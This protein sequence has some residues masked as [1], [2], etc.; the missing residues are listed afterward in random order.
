MQSEKLTFRNPD[1]QELA[2]ILDRPV[3]PDPAA[4]ALFAHCFTCSK[5][6]KAAH[7]VSRGLTDAGIAVLR[8]DF[9]GLGESEGEFANT[10]FS[11]NVADLVAAAEFLET[12]YRAPEIL[13]GHSL[14]GAA[15]LMAGEKIPSIRVVATIAAPADPAH[16]VKHLGNSREEIERKGEATV[17]LGGR[18]FQVRKQF[19][20]DLEGN[21]M[22]RSI[23]A[24]RR[25]AIL[26]FHSPL[27]SV[28]GI[29][30]AVKIYKAAIHPKSFVSLD[31]ADH[32]LSDPADSVYCGTVIS[33]LSRKY[34]AAAEARRAGKA[35]ALSGGQDETVARTGRE[36]YRTEISAAGHPLLADEPE[37]YGGTD[38]GPTPFD[39]LSAGLGA[40]TT[41]T[42]RMYADRKKW[43][44]EGARARVR[45][46]KVHVEE[47]ADCET[48]SG[49]IDEFTREIEL[50]GDLTE[51]QRQ[52]LLEIADRCPVHR[53]LHAEIKV[54]TRLLS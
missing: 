12:E 13:V 10:N 36:H 29:D 31:T 39:Y 23:R 37:S 16:V 28:V 52:R 20:D 15:V 46:R 40:C 33:A 30:N 3:S 21:R 54:R 35:D 32:L 25:K 19:L 7:H 34:L 50:E 6:V 45:H 47:C 8:F 53:T 44:L 51:E 4:Y 27:D 22:E 42:L 18:Q 1:G 43:P 26:I 24:L 14:G 2:A 48:E 5:N 9:T 49:K 41:M 17:T 38:A 11:S